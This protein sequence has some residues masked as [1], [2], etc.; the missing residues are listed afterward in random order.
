MNQIIS[1]L[2]VI[3]VGAITILSLWMMRT[4]DGTANLIQK[5]MDL[6]FKNVNENFNVLNKYI[7]RVRVD[8]NESIGQ[9][10]VD[11]NESIGQVRDD[12]SN[13]KDTYEDRVQYLER[14]KMEPTKTDEAYGQTT[15]ESQHNNQEQTES[16]LFCSTW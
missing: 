14:L 12:L 15:Q 2:P 3:L 13:F 1:A 8:L 10:R 4:C 6:R 9:V 5:N 16:I 11:M 7:D